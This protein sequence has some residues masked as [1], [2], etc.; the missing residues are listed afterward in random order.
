MVNISRLESDISLIFVLNDTEYM[1]SY[2]FFIW[3]WVVRSTVK[4]KLAKLSLNLDTLQYLRIKVSYE[5]AFSP[6]TI[7]IYGFL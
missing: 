6:N 4:P 3:T 2:R 1:V 5:L 7:Q